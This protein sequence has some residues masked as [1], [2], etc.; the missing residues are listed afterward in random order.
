MVAGV[1]RIMAGANGNGQRVLLWA[2]GIFA[3]M[4]S[5]VLAGFMGY[6]VSRLDHH[7]GLPGHPTMVERVDGVQDEL[8]E[9]Q[10]E[11]RDGMKENAGEH[12]EILEQLDRIEDK[13]D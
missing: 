9:L 3:S 13:V 2:L 6:V 1:L 10:T 7:G 8:D 4:S 11:F 12:R 5:L